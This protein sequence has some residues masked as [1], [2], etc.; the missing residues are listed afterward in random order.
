MAYT[1]YLFLAILSSFF[2]FLGS[3]IKVLTF[4]NFF[5]QV[6]FMIF[7]KSNNIYF[8]LALQIN[9]MIFFHFKNNNNNNKC[10]DGSSFFFFFYDSNSYNDNNC[11][12]L[13]VGE[14]W[15]FPSNV[16]EWPL[17][18]LGS[19]HLVLWLLGALTVF[20]DILDERLIA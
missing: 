19:Q 3:F 6:K 2:F 17:V 7:F 10:N 18:G 20:S 1:F 12:T 8:N 11:C 15:Y 5:L 14:W 13:F 9:F 4:F 16:L